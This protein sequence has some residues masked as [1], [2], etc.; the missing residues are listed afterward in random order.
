MTAVPLDGK[1]RSS[2]VRY[3]AATLMLVITAQQRYYMI[4]ALP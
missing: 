4:R 3:V 1:E 2:P